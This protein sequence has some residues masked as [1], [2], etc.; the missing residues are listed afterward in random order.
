MYVCVC[1]CVY[2]CMYTH[3]YIHAYIN[4]PGVG[5]QGRGGEEML[6]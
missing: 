1:V 5:M 3:K 4:M 6:S 2:V